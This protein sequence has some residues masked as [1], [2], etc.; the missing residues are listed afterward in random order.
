MS[1]GFRRVLAA[2]V[3]S[4]FG[5]MLSRLALPWLAAL[6]LAATPLH[7][8]WLVVADVAAGAF[9]ALVLGAAIDRAPKRAMML[10]C[11]LLRA[12][13]LAVLAVLAHRSLLRGGWPR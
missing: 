10:V 13:V 2:E 3:V 9:G 8:G 1:I 5:S 4:N 6:A 12:A 11:D 7:I